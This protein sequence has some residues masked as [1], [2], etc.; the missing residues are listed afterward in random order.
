MF[1]AGDSAR[2]KYKPNVRVFIVEVQKQTCYAGVEQVWYT[3]RQYGVGRSDGIAQKYDR[4]SSIELEPIPDASPKLK[5]LIKKFN[6][7]KQKQENY[8][9]KQDFEK[10]A[11]LKTE[12][13]NLKLEIEMLAEKEGVALILEKIRG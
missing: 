10:A 5:E 13:S 6:A 1:K 9:K 12:K 4:F 2:V 11:E 8:I 7:I 3:A